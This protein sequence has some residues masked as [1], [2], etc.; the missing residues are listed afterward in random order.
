V[1]SLRAAKYFPPVA[2]IDAAAGDR[3][4]ICSCEPLEA[5]ATSLEAAGSVTSRD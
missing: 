3:H 5:Y 2:R 4:L 1:P